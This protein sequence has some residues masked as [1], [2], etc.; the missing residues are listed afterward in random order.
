[1]A[2]YFQNFLNGEPPDPPS[3]LRYI[4]FHASFHNL[5]SLGRL[6]KKSVQVHA[7]KQ[8]FHCRRIQFCSLPQY[9]IP[10]YSHAQQHIFDNRYANP[11]VYEGEF[12]SLR[13]RAICSQ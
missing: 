8:L 9:E 7:R 2:I 11:M 10:F 4:T 3:K 13:G 12:Y 6:E 1:M 5:L